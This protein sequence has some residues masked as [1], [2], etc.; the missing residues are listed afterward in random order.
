MVLSFA[1]GFWVTSTRTAVGPARPGLAPFTTWWRES[2][3]LVPLYV[4]A[5]LGALLLTRLWAGRGS[6]RRGTL[7][8][9]TLMVALSGTVV[10]ILH[11]AAA[12]AADYLTQWHMLQMMTMMRA[13]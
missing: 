11:M 6:A 10:G 8:V 4:C 13:D 5:V 9:A 12:S 1:D 7:V 3:V 2:S